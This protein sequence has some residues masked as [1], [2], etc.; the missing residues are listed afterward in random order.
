MSCAS[1]PARLQ[2][3]RRMTHAWGSVAGWRSPARYDRSGG[4]ACDRYCPPGTTDAGDES[5]KVL[6]PS[7]S[8]GPG[9]SRSEVLAMRRALRR[10]HARYARPLRIRDNSDPWPVLVSEVMAQQTQIARAE[11]A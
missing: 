7:E 8:G 10:W 6:T 1:R 3:V 2:A 5:M 9:R 4:K 11:A